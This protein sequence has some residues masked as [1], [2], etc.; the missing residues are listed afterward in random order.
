MRSHL[1]FCWLLL[2]LLT[3]AQEHRVPAGSDGN[4]LYLA[5]HNSS[6]SALANVRV[7]VKSAADWLTFK[8]AEVILE[9]IPAAGWREAEFEFAVMNM[10][11]DAADT[12]LFN[13]TDNAGRLLG[14]RVLHFRSELLPKSTRLQPPFPNPANPSTTLQYDL[15]ALSEVKL[16][17]YNILGQRVRTLLNAEKPAGTFSIQWDGHNDRGIAVSSGTYIVRLT[18]RDIEQNKLKQLN[19]KTDHPEMKKGG[20]Q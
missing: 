2:P 10:Q 19:R 7:T 1:I 3:S 17:I 4:K 18:A 5:V 11:T 14:Q 16:E 15:H 13:I 12:V 20:V 6:E 8:S 9:S